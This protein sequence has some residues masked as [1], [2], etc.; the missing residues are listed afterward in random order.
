MAFSGLQQPTWKENVNPSIYCKTPASRRIVRV[1]GG[2]SETIPSAI[3]PCQRAR[4]SF[5]SS[6]RPYLPACVWLSVRRSYCPAVFFEMLI[7]KIFAE[8]FAHV[9]RQRPIARRRI[10]HHAAAIEQQC[11]RVHF[12]FSCPF[13]IWSSAASAAAASGAT[14]STV[15]MPRVFISA[16]SNF[17]TSSGR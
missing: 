7:Q 17:G 13:Q 16:L 2:A 5:T 1:D 4:N 3:C 10:N 15:C 6:N 14:I 8:D 9:L 12:V 11:F